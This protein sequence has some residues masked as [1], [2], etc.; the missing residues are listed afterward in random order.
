MY[1]TDDN[2][3]NIYI[4]QL[5]ILYR[6][7][8][9]TTNIPYI[10]ITFASYYQ[11]DTSYYIFCRGLCDNQHYGTTILLTMSIV[12]TVFHTLQCRCYNKS[13]IHSCV[14]ANKCDFICAGMSGIWLCICFVKMKLLLF[15]PCILLMIL[16]GI[17]K[18]HQYYTMYLILHGI[19]HITSAYIM[20]IVIRD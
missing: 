12:S 18:T 11:M 4:S 20:Y 8:F 16:G 7:L 19:W 10:L 13:C 3:H 1:D 17:C 5:N 15:V 6:I 14:I 2:A 9:I